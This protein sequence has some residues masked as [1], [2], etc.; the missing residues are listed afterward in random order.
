L[1]TNDNVEMDP[2]E[3][4]EQALQDLPDVNGAQSA[5]NEVKQNLRKFFPERDC[6]TMV[7]PVVKEDLL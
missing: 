5:K 4:L 6:F 1:V 7:R 2:K 3:Y